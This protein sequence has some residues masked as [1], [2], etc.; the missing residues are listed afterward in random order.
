MQAMAA[1]VPVVASWIRGNVDLIEDGVNGFLCD[2]E[3]ASGFAEGIRKILDD[4]NLAEEFR[5]NSLEKIKSFDVN[6]VTEQL[7][8]IYCEI[9]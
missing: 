2:P 5:N 7:K 1:G 8:K 6:E 9:I 3:D 4:P